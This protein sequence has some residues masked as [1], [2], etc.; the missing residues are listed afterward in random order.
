MGLQRSTQKP[1]RRRTAPARL[2]CSAGG[3]APGEGAAAQSS[4]TW[5]GSRDKG[6]ESYA[7]DFTAV[8]LSFPAP[9][10]QRQPQRAAQGATPTAAPESYPPR[11][12]RLPA[13]LSAPQRCPPPRRHTWKAPARTHRA[14]QLGRPSAEVS[15]LPPPLH[16]GAVHPP[17]LA[18][19]GCRAGINPPPPARRLAALTHTP[20]EG[21]LP[22]RPA[23]WPHAGS[24]PAACWQRGH[25]AEA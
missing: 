12:A 23:D 17:L 9:V 19:P 4:L 5:D 14:R 2:C 16:D 3:A 15:H 24:A 6:T 8:Y 20:W 1:C 18:A 7:V 22:D 11:Q 21:P 13:T 10:R 25:E